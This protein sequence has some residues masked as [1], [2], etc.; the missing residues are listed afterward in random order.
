MYWR[1]LVRPSQATSSKSYPP[2]LQQKF[3]SSKTRAGFSKLQKKSKPQ[4]HSLQKK[5][6]YTLQIA[7]YR[8]ERDA[9]YHSLS[10]KSQGYTAFYRKAL[11]RK[12][13]WY[14]VFMGLFDHYQEAR[15]FKNKLI[16]KNKLKEAFVFK[17]HEPSL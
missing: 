16:R 12:K 8:D 10:L 14:R 5:K 11:I 7:S 1:E 13:T 15:T 17:L 3:S 9:V 4:T 2:Q 6:N